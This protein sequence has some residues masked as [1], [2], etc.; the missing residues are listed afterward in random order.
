MGSVRHLK[1]ENK[2]DLIFLARWVSVR[3][4]KLFRLTLSCGELIDSRMY[5]KWS[6]FEPKW[7]FQLSLYKLS[8]F[9]C[10]LD[11]ERNNGKRVSPPYKPYSRGN[12]CQ[13]IFRYGIQSSPHTR[14]ADV[15]VEGENVCQ[16][17]CK[18]AWS[19]RV[20]KL[21]PQDLSFLNPPGISEAGSDLEIT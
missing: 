17:V 20:S 5:S 12:P 16:D 8:L 14:C 6:V 21:A 19:V 10:L 4:G 11:Q 9:I 18:A 3:G 2:S 15:F 13:V 1:A 7:R